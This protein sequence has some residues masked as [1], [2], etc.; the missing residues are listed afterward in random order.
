MV[1]CTINTVG[2]SDL[3]ILLSHLSTTISRLVATPKGGGRFLLWLLRHP[4]KGQ[5]QIHDLPITIQS[6][7]PRTKHWQGIFG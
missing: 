2:L 7:D 4:H 1:M 6:L 5:R 3:Y